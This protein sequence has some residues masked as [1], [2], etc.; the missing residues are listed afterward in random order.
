MHPAPSFLERYPP[1]SVVVFRAL[2]L[3][4][5]LCAVPALRA[6]R[7]AVGGVRITLVGLPWARQFAERYARYVDEFVAFPGDPDLPEQPVRRDELS[8]FYAAMR[9]RRFDLAIQLHGSGRHSNRIVQ[10]FGARTMAAFG[11]EASTECSLRLSYP[12][13]GHES[14]RLQALMTA[15]G[16]A[17]TGP[18]LE[19]PIFADDERELAD[20][21]IA[22]LLPSAPYVCVHPGARWRDKC[23]HPARFAA[24]ADALANSHGVRIVLTGSASERDLTQAVAAQMRSPAI[25]TASPL[26]I[27]AM[28]VIMRGAALLIANDT[29]VSH[30]AAGLRLPSVIIFSKAA[31]ARWAPA[32]GTL[33]RCIR[34][35]DG[36]G[37]QQVLKH[38]DELLRQRL[39]APLPQQVN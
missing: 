9:A 10:A 13:Q 31:M 1:A 27:G 17:D 29:G 34:D 30:I 33:H 16:A 15:L 25:D 3:G 39:P 36:S 19:F 22:R 28:A 35:P 32:D 4:D 23:W 8:G 24:V 11:G 20:S 5:M 7:L 18:A 2:Q 21:S 26:S 37:V 6:L 12:D 14:A 38:A